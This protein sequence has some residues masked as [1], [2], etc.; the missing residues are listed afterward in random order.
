VVTRIVWT[1]SGAGIAPDEFDEFEVSA[2]PLPETDQLV[3]KALQ[4]YA[5]GEVV[6]WIEEAEEG[7]EEPEHPAPVLALAA[8]EQ[9]GAG[10]APVVAEDAA[11]ETEQVASTEAADGTAT[12]LAG[13]A[14]A[15][16]VLAVAG[17]AVAVVR[18]RRSS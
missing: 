13:A 16:A 10:S 17:A 1:A 3:F 4:T 14:L 12:T 9:E 18:T 6:R 2:G 8:T 5:D 15:V 7:A 11:P